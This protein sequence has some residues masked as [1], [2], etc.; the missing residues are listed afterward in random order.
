MQRFDDNFDGHVSIS[1]G[2]LILKQYLFTLNVEFVYKIF[3]PVRLTSYQINVL[4][5]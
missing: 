4:I 3:T 2:E 5:R 1:L